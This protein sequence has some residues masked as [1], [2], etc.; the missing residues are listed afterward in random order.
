M[1]ARMQAQRVEFNPILLDLD[2]L[3]RSVL[4][5]FQGQ[6]ESK[7]RLDY[8]VSEGMREVLLDN[9]LMR[10]ILTNLV[11]NAIK[12]SPEG[13]DVYI[14]LDYT[15]AEVILKVSDEGIGIPKAD[16]P[17]LFEPFHRAANVGTISG[18][19]LGLVITREAVELHGGT[20][21]VESQQ[22]VGTTFLIRIPIAGRVYSAPH[23]LG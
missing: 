12:Y 13:K 10:Q 9:K 23:P 11:S 20:I 6:A 8:T 3:V 15:D 21:T 14:H 5:E 19:G 17:H 22:N 7:H 18:T 16:L 2:A 4:D 1:L